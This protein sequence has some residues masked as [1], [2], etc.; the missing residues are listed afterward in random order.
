MRAGRHRLSRPR[1]RRD[2]ITGAGPALRR[3][4]RLGRLSRD[5]YAETA[6][7]QRDPKRRIGQVGMVVV[8]CHGGPVLMLCGGVIGKIGCENMGLSK[9]MRC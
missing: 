4:A 2:S 9:S 6:P 8:L 1:D 5:R 7:P 3:Q